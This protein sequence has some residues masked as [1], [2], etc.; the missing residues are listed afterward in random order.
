MA[1]NYWHFS[2]WICVPSESLWYVSWFSNNVNYIIS[3]FTENF[4]YLIGD[5]TDSV[6]YMIV[7]YTENVNYLVVYILKMLITW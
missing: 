4:N 2:E 1:T 5:C 6:N 7:E 3:D